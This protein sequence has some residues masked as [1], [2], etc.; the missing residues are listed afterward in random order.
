MPDPLPPAPHYEPV[1]SWRQIALLVAV[2]V[3]V[4]VVAT[5]WLVSM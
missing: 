3:A 2:M 1:T 5:L 4:V